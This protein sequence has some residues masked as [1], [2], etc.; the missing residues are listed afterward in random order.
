MADPSLAMAT[1]GCV[2]TSRTSF[3]DIVWN[4]R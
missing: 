3:S 1:H 4:T 2:I